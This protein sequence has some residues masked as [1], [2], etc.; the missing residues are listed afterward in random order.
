[1]WGLVMSRLNESVHTE[2]PTHVY[3]G[4]HDKAAPW[5]SLAP[6]GTGLCDRLVRWVHRGGG[7]SRWVLTVVRVS[8]PGCTRPVP[9]L[10]QDPYQP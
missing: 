2:T 9:G 5:A 6:W 3:P 7:V 10:Y 8:V 4:E 1:M